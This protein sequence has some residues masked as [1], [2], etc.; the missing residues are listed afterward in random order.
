[1]FLR[2]VDFLPQKYKMSQD[3]R[4]LQVFTFQKASALI[5]FTCSIIRHDNLRFKTAFEQFSIFSVSYNNSTPPICKQIGSALCEECRIVKITEYVKR[6]L[7][8]DI[9][10]SNAE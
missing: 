3:G 4:G 5:P 7:E 10:K 6:G 8:Y 9:Y 2:K 1:M